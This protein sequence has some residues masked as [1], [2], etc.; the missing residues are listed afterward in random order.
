MTARCPFCR[1]PAG[2]VAVTIFMV[3]AAIVLAVMKMTAFLRT[4]LHSTNRTARISGRLPVMSVMCRNRHDQKNRYHRCRCR[5]SQQFSQAHD[6]YLLSLAVRHI[7]V[8]TLSSYQKNI[9]LSICRN[10]IFS[11]FIFIHLQDEIIPV[12]MDSGSTS[13]SVSSSCTLI[14]TRMLSPLLLSSTTAIV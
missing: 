11:P 12:T 3:I 9:L 4:V 6:N 1:G 8:S 10:F 14:F 5:R 7:L 13:T 2:T